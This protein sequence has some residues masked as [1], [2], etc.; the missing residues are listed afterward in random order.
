MAGP[1]CCENPPTLTSW[2]GD[3]AVEEIGGLN[4]YI[5]GST[6]STA[7]VILISDIYGME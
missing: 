1:Q 3:G 4:A 7:A 6:D 5:V 2:L